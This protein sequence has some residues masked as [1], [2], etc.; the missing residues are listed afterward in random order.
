MK[1]RPGDIFTIPVDEE[2]TGF[3][4]IIN[5]PNKNN[6]LIVVFERVYSGREWPSLKEIIQDRVLFLGYTMD[7]L[8]Y[9]KEWRIIGN[10]SSNL[11]KIKLP[12]FKLGTAPDM[13]IVTFKG[14]VV[15]RASKEEYD[16]LEYETVIAP[17]RYENALKAYHKLDEWKEDY[18]KLFYERTLESVKVAERK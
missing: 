7:A 2:K 16:N 18:D 15:R 9:H 4:Q 6:F 11:S 10:D 3:G 12:Y 14:D 1:L 5:I 8:L 13:N 17:V